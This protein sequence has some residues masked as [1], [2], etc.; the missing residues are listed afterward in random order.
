MLNT[1]AASTRNSATK[2]DIRH[3]FSR[4]CAQLALSFIAAVLLPEA[5][6]ATPFKLYLQCRHPSG[7]PSHGK[8]GAGTENR[9]LNRVPLKGSIRITIRVLQAYCNI[10][11]LITSN[12]ILGVPYYKL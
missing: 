11:A 6:S 2:P 5:L 3:T 9:G 10:G 7:D 4:N 1:H 12:T 8:G